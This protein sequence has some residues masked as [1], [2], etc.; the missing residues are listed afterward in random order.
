M[1][2]IKES[3]NI[4]KEIVKLRD[5]FN[6]INLKNKITLK[7]LE[8]LKLKSSVFNDERLFD[9]YLNANE[10]EDSFFLHDLSDELTE[11]EIRNDTEF[12]INPKIKPLK[13][14]KIFRETQYYRKPRQ[15]NK[16]LL[17]LNKDINEN[18]EDIFRVECSKKTGSPHNLEESEQEQ[19][20][21][22][23]LPL[24]KLDVNPNKLDEP[25]SDLQNLLMMMALPSK[26]N[27]EYQETDDKLEINSIETPKSEIHNSNVHMNNEPKSF[28]TSEGI[29]NILSISPIRIQIESKETF[30]L[31]KFVNKWKCYVNNR[32]KYVSDQRQ[33]TLNNFFDK[34]AKKKMD[35]NQISESEN[36]SKLL[37]KDYNTYQ[38]R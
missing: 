3:Y 8:P 22:S 6:N 5:D 12:K 28:R 9:K 26:S 20:S 15:G 37:A 34:I 30:L 7:A 31:K 10:A 18:N 36:K 35:I 38:H 2:R 21:K 17:D 4:S 27:N 24:N 32:K 16:G 13:H 14:I 29:E 25:A 33:E 1:K 19:P 11:L 23:A